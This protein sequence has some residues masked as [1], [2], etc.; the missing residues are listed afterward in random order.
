MMK[1]TRRKKTAFYQELF[2][3]G[4]MKE[5]MPVSKD[6]KGYALLFQLKMESDILPGFYQMFIS[7]GMK[8]WRLPHRVM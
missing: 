1:N 6:K 4:M 5:L 8:S 2:K 3:L 7:K